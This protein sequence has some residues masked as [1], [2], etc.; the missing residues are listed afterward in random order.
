MSIHTKRGLRRIYVLHGT[1]E[2]AL[3]V[4]ALALFAVPVSN[5]QTPLASVGGV[6]TDSSGAEIPGVKVTVKDNQRGVSFE[7]Q[8]NQTGFYVITELIPSTYRVTA[9]M[10]GFGTFAVDSFPL[11]TQQKAVLNITLQLGTM[12]ET[13]EVTGRAQMLEPSNATLGGVVE[14]KAVI[15]L[16]LNNRNVFG[17]MALLP[18]VAPSLPNNYQNEVFVNPVRFSFNGGLESTSDIQLDGI[19]ALT[20]SDISGIY[21]ASALPSV[22]S[23]E[24]FRAQTNSFS[25]EYGRSGGGVVTMVTKSGTNAFHGT[26]FEF[27]RNN[28]MDSNNFFSNRSGGKLAPLRQHQYGGV[29]GGPVIKNRTFFFVA[30]EKRLLHSGNFRLFTVPT[31]LERQGDFSQTFNAAGQ[32][33][34]MYNPFS[35][36]P[37]PTNPGGFIRDPF[38]GN[39]I[40]RNFMDPVALRAMAFYPEPNQ[41][42]LPFTHQNNLGITGVSSSPR[43][44]IDFK[45]NHNL[46]NTKRFFVRYNL[47]KQTIGDINYWNNPA[48]QTAG[49]LAWTAHNAQLDYIQTFGN[50]TVLNL[51]A[52]FG[53]F[54]A[55]RPSFGFPFD[56]TSLGL[57]ASLA[58]FQ[59]K[60]SKPIFPTLSIADRSQLGPPAGVYFQSFNTTHVMVGSLSHVVGRHTLKVGGESRTYLLNFLQVIRPFSGDFSRRMTQGP[61]PLTASNVAGD[62]FASFLMGTGDGG[63]SLFQPTTANANHYYAQ[64]VQDD[65][66]WT[67]KLTMN[68]GFRLEE[69]TGTTERYDRLASIDPTVLNPISNNVG[70]NVYGGYV[71]AG[72]GPDS[73]GRRAIRPIEYKPNPRVGVAYELNDRTVVRAGYG[74]YFGVTRAGATALFTGSPFSTPTTWLAT[75]DGVTPNA[76]LSN[77]FPQGF[78]FPPGSS[79]GLLSAVGSTLFSGWPQTLRT[80]YNQQWNLTI[81]RTIAK[82]TMLQLAYA[83]NKGTHLAFG[84][85][86]GPGPNMNQ[87]QPSQMSQG[88]ALLALVPNPFFGF[89][90]EGT[91]AQPMIQRGQLLRPFPAWT[92]VN[93]IMGGDANSTYH[94][95]QV[96]LQRRF[97]GGSTFMASYTR[98]RMM[99]DGADGTWNDQNSGLGLG[100]LRNWYC[101]SCERAVSSY[102]VPNRFV[103]SF[104][105]ELPFGKGKQFGSSWHGITNLVLGGW[106]TNG[107]LTLASGQPLVF[108]VAQNTSFS[109]GGGQHPDATGVDANLGSAQSVGRWFNQA[110]FAQPASFTFGNLGRT[111]TS[112]RNDWTRN[113]DFSLFKRFSI[114]ERLDL[115]FRAEAYNLTNTPVFGAPNTSL[116][117]A[118][119]GVIS[120]QSNTPRQIQLALKVLF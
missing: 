91:L 82:D 59:D 28:A 85:C 103:L 31:A 90:K 83:G 3:M 80:A 78:L 104:V 8:T 76:L 51:R 116:G 49:T 43:T 68:L 112:V 42:G 48:I 13:V 12:T 5:A 117:S 6:V 120:G 77:P 16:P 40:P 35:T 89:I 10:S 92:T 54:A 44:R 21:G 41:S 86:N 101:R 11:S 102:D 36:R 118:A 94:A 14:N 65:I 4:L 96:L 74:I 108:S 84:C 55:F 87:L 99:S 67:P 52:G 71:F 58:D 105:Y 119:F 98:A 30:V 24:E 106:Q 18:G 79:A 72:S 61:N 17:L 100:G 95:L 60:G 39:I 29:L 37:D 47:L 50:A 69:E 107:I 22:E 115:E 93:P 110:A 27:L 97:V 73:L 15:D 62:G 64:Y 26:V 33:R 81:Q 45:V 32:L 109:F 75:L 46:S 38:P 56:V 9:E 53:R 34:V 23:I 1:I 70:F 88:N 66:K 111:F 2:A 25:A 63:G 57:P 20:Q 113:M 7:T 114:K 19:S